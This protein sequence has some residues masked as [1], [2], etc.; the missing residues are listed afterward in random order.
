MTIPEV[1]ASA[2][3]NLS[4]PAQLVQAVPYLLGHAGLNDDLVLICTRA[5]RHTL[6]MRTDLALLGQVGLWERISAPLSAAGAD[7][8][9]LI[10]T[11]RG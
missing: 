2:R 5:E 11:R 3:V 9:H 4:G 1:P 8:V 6:A 7:A 10:A